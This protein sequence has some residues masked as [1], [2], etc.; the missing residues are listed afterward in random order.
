[1]S[2]RQIQRDVLLRYLS[3]RDLEEYGLVSKKNLQIT[4]EYIGHLKKYTKRLGHWAPVFYSLVTFLYSSSGETLWEEQVS[5]ASFSMELRVTR[6]SSSFELDYGVY[7]KENS[8][9]LDDPVEELSKM[10]S[11]GKK[12]DLVRKVYSVFSQIFKN[13]KESLELS[14][15]YPISM[16]D[17]PMKLKVFQIVFPPPK[18]I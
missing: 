3:Q 15:S 17:L 13:P 8:R 5:N 12:N 2:I 11:A 16:Y 4:T 10:Y 1:M 14:T 18:N 7:P 9:V 6:S